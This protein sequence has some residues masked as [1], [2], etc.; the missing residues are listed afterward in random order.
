M[1]HAFVH[2]HPSTLSLRLMSCSFVSFMSKPKADPWDVVAAEREGRVGGDILRNLYR[3]ATT[4]EPKQTIPTRHI[5]S[6]ISHFVVA[7]GAQ[8]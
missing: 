6:P 4:E 8:F 3:S 7:P 2:M 5:C 1:T